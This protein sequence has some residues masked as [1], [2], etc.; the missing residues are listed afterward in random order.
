M[1]NMNL[2]PLYEMQAQLD[3]R[4]VK[5]HSLDPTTYDWR[6]DALR[7]ELHECEN[8]SKHFKKWSTKQ[9]DR[10]KL[11]EEYVDA[12]HFFLSLGNQF[13]KRFDWIQ[14]GIV[15]SKLVAEQFRD[16][17]AFVLD[18]YESDMYYQ[19]AFGL[20]IG[21]GI[22]LGFTWDE[23]ERAYYAKNQKNH[24]RQDTGY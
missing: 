20:F 15:E 19:V 17:I 9:P 8:E 11:L 5:Q 12:L 7:V 21:L 13:D 1:H 22:L 10:A 4:I 16:V 14:P 6:I 18:L 3:E 23:V 24:V 2:L